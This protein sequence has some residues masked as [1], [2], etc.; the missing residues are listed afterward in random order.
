MPQI[1]HA[2]PVPPYAEDIRSALF[3]RMPA[4]MTEWACSP[5]PLEP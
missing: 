3:H 2:C 5:V 1:S 4:G